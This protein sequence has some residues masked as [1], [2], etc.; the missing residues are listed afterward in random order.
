MMEIQRFKIGGSLANSNDGKN[1]SVLDTSRFINSEKISEFGK[2]KSYN[3]VSFLY[4]ETL[5]LFDGELTDDRSIFTYRLEI[6]VPD[7]ELI[8]LLEDLRGNET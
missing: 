6:N 3:I 8:N 4:N 7:I 1:S 2:G 5:S